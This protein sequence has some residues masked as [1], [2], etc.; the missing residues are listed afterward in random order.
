MIIMNL[1]LCHQCC[2]PAPARHLRHIVRMTE[3]LTGVDWILVTNM[4]NLLNSLDDEDDCDESGKVLLGE[5]GDVTDSEAGIRGDHDE[6]D[7]TNPETNPQP[8]GEVVPLQSLTE[9]V[10]NGLKHEDRSSAAEDGE[11]LT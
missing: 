4:N 5:P 11:R 1:S 3:T 7:D 2:V 6:E 8:E 9:L 10:D